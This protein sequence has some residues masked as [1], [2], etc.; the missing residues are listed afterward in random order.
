MRA[1]RRDG[2]SQNASRHSKKRAYANVDDSSVP[3]RKPTWTKSR[4]FSFLACA[5]TAQTAPY[6]ARSPPRAGAARLVA[7][8]GRLIYG[9]C[10]VLPEENNGQVRR[11]LSRHPEFEVLPTSELWGDERAAQ[12]GDGRTLR[13]SPHRHGTDGFF[14]VVLQRAT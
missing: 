3:N 8:G 10:S 12:L 5:L 4:S 9:T 1:L 14:G 2:A 7:P 13:V 6:S 11:F